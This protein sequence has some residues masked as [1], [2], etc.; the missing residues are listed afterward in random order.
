M[1]TS[2]TSSLWYP[3]D[4]GSGSVGGIRVAAACEIGAIHPRRGQVTNDVE[5]ECRGA[6]RILARPALSAISERWPD[7]IDPLDFAGRC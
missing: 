5:H 7:R 6:R 4:S 1:S 3:A 2:K